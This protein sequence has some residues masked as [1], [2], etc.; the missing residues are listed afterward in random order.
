[1]REKTTKTQLGARDER[2]KVSATSCENTLL[3]YFEYPSPFL[4]GE[5]RSDISSVH[6]HGQTFTPTL[7]CDQ[8]IECNVTA[9]GTN[10]QLH[11]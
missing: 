2:E 8:K 1:M 10:A 6:L 7:V 9:N 11:L 3:V 4:W 5:L